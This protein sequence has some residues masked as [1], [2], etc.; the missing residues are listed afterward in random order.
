ML[1]L[2]KF[3]TSITDRYLIQL[4]L[5]RVLCWNREART[6]HLCPQLVVMKLSGWRGATWWQCPQILLVRVH[7]HI[8]TSP[9]LKLASPLPRQQSLNEYVCEIS[10]IYAEFERRP[11][12]NA[13]GNP[14]GTLGKCPK[15]WNS[16][17]C[18]AW[19]TMTLPTIINQ[20]RGQYNSHFIVH[21]ANLKQPTVAPFSHF[22]HILVP[23]IDGLLHKV[24]RL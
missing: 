12:Q 9:A 13:D 20:Q 6:T 5:I 23:W 15:F 3:K 14:T 17:P 22:C 11:L 24:T 19:V 21:V 8:K 10:L 7:V 18:Y 1:Q 2:L 4:N 16:F